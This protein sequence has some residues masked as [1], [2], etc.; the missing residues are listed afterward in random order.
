MLI[1]QFSLFALSCLSPCDL[2]DA[3]VDIDI[4]TDV[5]FR[6]SVSSEA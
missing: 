3:S 1:V 5:D 2:L 6:G 4:D